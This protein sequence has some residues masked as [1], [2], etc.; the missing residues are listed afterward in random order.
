M[1][2]NQLFRYQPPM[3]LVSKY[4]H[5]FGLS[6]IHDRNW[7]SVERLRQNRTTEQIKTK[8]FDDLKNLYIECKAKSFLSD[9]TEHSALTI[10]RQLAR[11]KGHNLNTRTRTVMGK[12]QLEYQITKI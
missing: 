6:G 12:K 1:A 11:T 3:E 8:L 4:L 5:L 9:I 7:F 2:I 10:L